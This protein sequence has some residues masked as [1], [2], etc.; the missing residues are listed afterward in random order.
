MYIPSRQCGPLALAES[1]DLGR[2]C[3]LAA[4]LAS[5]LASA[6]CLPLEGRAGSRTFAGHLNVARLS[7][8]LDRLR[9]KWRQIGDLAEPGS[10]SQR[11]IIVVCSKPDSLAGWP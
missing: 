9:P 4:K 1:R 8:C 7:V 2:V 6:C 11:S 5:R 3:R 10:A